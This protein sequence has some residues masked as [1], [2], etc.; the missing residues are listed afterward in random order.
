MWQWLTEKIE[1][2]P[3]HTADADGILALGGDLSSERLILAYNSG[4]FPW[5][6]DDEPVVW[7]SPP[8]RFVIFPEKL[9]ISKTMRQVLR[10]KIFKV[11]FD[12]NF[13]LIIK[14]CQQ[15]NREGQEGTWIT[16]DMQ[17]AYNLL[18]KKGVAHS[19]EVWQD[20]QIVGGLYGLIIGGVFCG[21]SMF[22]H[23]SNASKA[24]F[25]T[26]VKTLQNYGL[27]L[28]DCQ[29]Y[30]QH[31]GSLGAEMIQRDEFVKILN[32]EKTKKLL[33]E[34]WGDLVQAEFV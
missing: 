34:N 7:W 26:L 17:D 12:K 2:P 16:Q 9:N 6:N 23:R 31:L 30:T 14:N 13:P 8:E 1:F 32:Q 25:I 5:F 22:A 24:G 4:I 28:I 33:P 29:T 20:D 18:H 19:V 10:K 11:T 27:A 3:L 21:E 15:Q